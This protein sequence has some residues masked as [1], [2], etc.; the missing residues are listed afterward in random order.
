MTRVDVQAALRE[1]QQE[2]VDK[3]RITA[4]DIAREAWAIALDPDTPAGARV[5]ALALLAKR[6]PE[7]S[8]KHHIVSDQRVRVEALHAVASL[9]TD[10]LRQLAAGIE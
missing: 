9:T 4:D 3:L 6:H 2:I 7:Y 8:D 10:Q 1:S 5:Q